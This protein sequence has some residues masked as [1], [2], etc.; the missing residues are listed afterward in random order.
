MSGDL[1]EVA[2]E[3]LAALEEFEIQECPRCGGRGVESKNDRDACHECGGAG[4]I[5]R[6]GWPEHVRAAITKARPLCVTVT[7]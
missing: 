3:M 5:I 2:R 1:T 7:P 4:E 6:G